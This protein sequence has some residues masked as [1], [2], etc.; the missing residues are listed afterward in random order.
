MKFSNEKLFV[1]G[2]SSD[3]MTSYQMGTLLH[4]YSNFPTLNETLFFN[5]VSTSKPTSETKEPFEEFFD[6][7]I[8]EKKAFLISG[9]MTPN[10]FAQVKKLLVKVYCKNL[11]TAFY[12]IEFF[13]AKNFKIFNKQ[14]NYFKAT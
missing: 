11:W 3:N 2:Y 13:K 1:S 4:S 14:F 6:Y 10:K 8:F 7:K 9:L 5:N 12:S